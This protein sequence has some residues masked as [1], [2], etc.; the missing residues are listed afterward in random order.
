MSVDL[1]APLSP[2]R[3]TTSPF[4]TWKSTFLS[5]W[6]PEYHLCRPLV[7]MSGASIAHISSLMRLDGPPSQAL[8]TTARMIS[9]ADREF[10]PVCLDVGQDQTVVDDANEQRPDQ[11]AENRADA[12]IERSPADH[13]R[14]DGLQFQAFA[15]GWKRRTEPQD[16]NRSSETRQN[17]AQHEAAHL[18]RTGRNAHRSGR[19][20]LSA[21]RF[22][23]IAEVGERQDS[24]ESDSDRCEPEH[25]EANDADIMGEDP[26]RDVKREDRRKATRYDDRD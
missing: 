25:R 20:D 9:V 22:N 10:K 17:G 11:R 14:C 8:P 24:S 5:A 4:E 23:P 6:T 15:Q 3:P 2:T 18:D 26:G 16:L 19:V 13:R 21:G 7:S 1:P 12:A